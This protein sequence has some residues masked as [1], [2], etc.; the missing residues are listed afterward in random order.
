MCELC[1]CKIVVMLFDLFFVGGM[2]WLNVVCV[3]I[4]VEIFDVVCNVVFE[5]IVGVFE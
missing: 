4:G 1:I 3:C 2:E 5:M